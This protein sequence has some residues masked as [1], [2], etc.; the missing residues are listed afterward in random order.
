MNRLITY[1]LFSFFFISFQGINATTASHST[2]LD[3]LFKKN[4]KFL[5]SVKKR[6]N[7]NQ[8]NT[9]HLSV[10]SIVPV[11]ST[12]NTVLSLAKDV[13]DSLEIHNKYIDFLTSDHLYSL[14]VGIKKQI[15]NITYIMGILKA[16][17]TPQSTNLTTFVKIILPETNAQGEQKELF[18]GADDIKF[19]HQGGIYGDAKLTLLGDVSIPLGGSQTDTISGNETLLVLRGGFDMNSGDLQNKTYVTVDCNGF[20]ELSINADIL[21]SR[22]LIEP[23]NDNNQVI[24][25][26]DVRVT[27]HFETTASSWDDILA[28]VTLSR[29]QIKKAQT[30]T[31]GKGGFIFDVG[32]AIFDFSD[33]RNHPNM[34]FPPEYSDYLISGQEQLWKGVYIA[35]AQIILPEQFKK[36]N[37]S[38][39]IVFNVSDLLI[40]NWGVTGDFSVDNILSINEGE[41]DKWQFSVDHL[42]AKF[43]VNDL[44]TAEFNGKIV[45]PITKKV[46]I[47]QDSTS[48]QNKSL[49]YNAIINP[50]ADD[51]DLTVQT[52]DTLSFDIFKAKATLSP[53][54]YVELKVQDKKFKPKAVLN[55]SMGI[56]ASN[57]S[58]NNDNKTVNF[59]GIEF[60]NLVIKTDSLSVDYLGYN[61]DV[62]LAGFPV[63]LSNINANVT[64]NNATLHFDIAVN[65][66]HNGFSGDTGVDIVAKKQEVD[67]YQRWGFDH[68]HVDD[69]NL[70]AEINDN[71]K[72]NGLIQIKENDPVYGNG[73]YGQINA[74][75]TSINITA[76][77]WF[78]K[79][80]FRYWYVDAFADLSNAN[81]PVKLGIID[82]TGFGGGA[83]YRMSKTGGSSLATP[84]GL[85][86]QPDENA[87]FGFRAML[88]YAFQNK[89]AVN[90]RLAFEM[91]FNSSGGLNRILFYGSA[92]IMQLNLPI[93]TNK[94]KNNLKLAD[95]AASDPTGDLVNKS[96]TQFP[97]EPNSFDT[98]LNA[99]LGMEMDFQ[100]HS[101]EAQLKTYINAAGGLLRGGNANNL[102]GNAILHIDSQNWYLYVGTPDQRISL[103]FGIKSLSIQT[104][105]YLM[106]GNQIQGSP[107]PPSEVANILGLNANDLDSMR[108]LN[109]LGNG[110]GFAMGMSLSMDTGDLTFL[111]FYAHFQAGLGFDIMVKDYGNTACAGSGQIGINGWYANGQAYVYLQGDI[112]IKVTLFG[113]TKKASILS[114]SAAALMQAK[115]PNPSW[116]R[117]YV[118]G[119]YSVLGGLVSGH[120]RFKVELGQE[121]EIVNG[122]PLGGIKIISEI[123]PND[124]TQAVDVFTK[125][126]VTFNMK[127]NEAFDLEADGQTKTYKIKLEKFEVTDQGNPV[128]GH[129]EWNTTKDVLNFVSD[130]ILPENENL[131]AFVKVIFQE[132]QGNSWHTITQNGQVAEETEEVDFTTGP[133]PN[134]IPLSNIE[135]CYP[136]N[137]QK[138]FYPGE[139][140]TGYIKLIQGQPNIFPPQTDWTQMIKVS[141]PSGDLTA[142]QVSYDP[143]QRQVNFSIPQGLQPQ[144][145]YELKIL[146]FPPQQQT[147]QNDVVYDTVQVS[148]SLNVQIKNVQAQNVVQDD[149]ATEVV[150]INFTTSQYQTFADKM[151]AKIRANSL[152]LLEIANVFSLQVDAQ[153]TEKFG[154]AEVQGSAFTANAPLIKTRAI[155]DDSYYLNTIYPLIYQN[156]PLSPH[157]F[158][159]DRTDIDVIGLP[160]DRAVLLLTWYPDY[161]QNSPNDP[162]LN[163]RLPYSYNLP[164]YYYSDFIDL[165]TKVTN[166]Y[167]SSGNHSYDY[168]INSSFPMMPQGSYKVRYTYVLPGNIEGS[169]YDYIYTKDF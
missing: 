151:S 86:Y 80:T 78:G 2:K 107:P 137:E 74:Q 168:I 165:R 46:S 25:N 157:H 134:Y 55:G 144:T 34:N 14:P 98:G 18:F 149:I 45:L 128:S 118:G 121:C 103:K 24:S 37:S 131:H 94:F 161:L 6:K 70:Q 33:I 132:K 108:D 112:G 90:G 102:A 71:L 81:V 8:I 136:V 31:T 146:S 48:L 51:Y 11:D 99:Y 44:Q 23:V 1:F 155:L 127:I 72:L 96:K 162:I 57:S 130:D 150:N 76:S 20:K 56:E 154:L 64:N 106:V 113:L 115:L 117:G 92:H 36:R 140:Q 26:P 35:N 4:N 126:Q 42:E 69:I 125:P 141:G 84:S 110:A 73:F 60:Q 138:Y 142:N 38:N 29:F 148:D 105:A 104:D 93:D 164:H 143:N 77:A 163:T 153:P 16:E 119:D 91:A 27:G 3:S 109:A 52:Q 7:Y 139:H 120:Y 85:D 135:Y 65:M 82:I 159:V 15:G 116:F 66:M 166:A 147:Q 67:G 30:S 54:S 62:K 40:D 19:S 39:R 47:S 156:Y 158:T 129:L 9:N 88:G 58:N 97:H 87:G 114:G 32:T 49:S 101:F 5:N 13:F 43:L 12:T 124:G 28:S 68:F 95:T 169:H 50:G 53:N 167:Y 83:Y 145:Q 100:N 160:P 75:F 79:T 21:F 17:I 133:E 10:K 152:A 59:K 22:D 89:K 41:A 123:K 111:I 63:T 61:G 122:N